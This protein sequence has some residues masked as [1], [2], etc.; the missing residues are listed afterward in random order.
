[1]ALVK[2]E[3]FEMKAPENENV[4]K[5]VTKAVRT[6]G[7]TLSVSKLGE[8]VFV[9]LHALLIE[10]IR[11]AL[12][13]SMKS[14]QDLFSKHDSNKDGFL[15]Y[16]ECENLFLECQIAFKPN[17]VSE[18]FSILDPGH[19]FSKIS[20]QTLKFYLSDNSSSLGGVRSYDLEPS[21]EM[22]HLSEGT[23]LEELN[24]CRVAARKILSACQNNLPE[25]LTKVDI[26]NEGI[27]GREDIIKVLE[28]QKVKDLSMGE[29]N[30]VLKFADKGHKGYICTQFFLDKLQ[31]LAVESKADTM[32]RRLATTLKHQGID[33]RV[34][35]QKHEQGGK[36]IR[37]DKNTFAKA[38]KQ[39]S[40]ALTNEEIDLLFQ[41][42]EVLEQKG[43]MD[44]RT[45]ITK[46][47]QAQKSKPLPTFI[48]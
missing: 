13:K 32:L 46:I 35:M 8:R 31:E 44:I 10:K 37:L 25:L 20:F 41:S 34:E 16:S 3:N 45:F 2:A 28:E 30:L 4:F 23:S 48:A 29:L 12:F 1:M 15:T 19:K 42:S 5:Y 17:M 39:L 9:A 22:V 40:V 21:Q 6:T 43:H 24:V 7:V 11:D 26:H 27:I 38:M 36:N 47:N 33:I 18:V 14:L